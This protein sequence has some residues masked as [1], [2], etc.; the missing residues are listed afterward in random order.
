MGW[1]VKTPKRIDFCG[2]VGCPLC[3]DWVEEPPPPIVEVEEKEPEV[4]AEPVVITGIQKM[5][6]DLLGRTTGTA[7]E[8]A[9]LETAAIAIHERNL[10]KAGEFK[11]NFQIKHTTMQVESVI[12]QVRRE[13]AAPKR[14]PPPMNT[15]NLDDMD[16]EAVRKACTVDCEVD[17]DLL[18]RESDWVYLKREE[19]AR[20][21]IRTLIAKE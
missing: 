19:T 5:A 1:V 21:L 3:Y 6:K 18:R 8:K 13:R 17:R 4:V 10:V 16:P 20:D 11:E 15:V 14:E 2:S 12:K 7:E 9:A